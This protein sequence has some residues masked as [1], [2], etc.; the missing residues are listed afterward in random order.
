M[1]SAYVDLRLEAGDIE[2]IGGPELSYYCELHG[3]AMGNEIEIQNI[4]A[5]N[6]SPLMRGWPELEK[7]LATLTGKVAHHGAN[8]IRQC[9]T[10]ARLIVSSIKASPRVSL[11]YLW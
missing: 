10:A 4:V 8:S 6:T 5:W 3:A 1:E 11:H 7:R 9:L 2:N